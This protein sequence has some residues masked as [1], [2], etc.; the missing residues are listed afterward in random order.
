[1][2]HRT[3]RACKLNHHGTPVEALYHLAIGN[4]CHIL[5]LHI[6]S[7]VKK[8]RRKGR[9]RRWCFGKRRRNRNLRT[10]LKPRVFN[11][12]PLTPK[13]RKGS[14]ISQKH[15]VGVHRGKLAPA[16][17]CASKTSGE[18]KNTPPTWFFVSNLLD[19]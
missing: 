18:K 15:L 17:F 1:M 13:I 14:K 9:R 8:S 4:A 19:L 10:S 11:P 6:R 12:D 2:S 5:Y 3:W 16:V 7:R